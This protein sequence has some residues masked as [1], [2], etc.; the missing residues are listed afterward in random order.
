[1]LPVNGAGMAGAGRGGGSPWAGWA[2]AQVHVALPPR[3]HLCHTSPEGSEPGSAVVCRGA[4]GER[5]RTGVS[6]Q[7]KPCRWAAKRGGRAHSGV[8]SSGEAQRPGSSQPGSQGAR[9]GPVRGPTIPG[10]GVGVGTAAAVAATG[11]EQPRR[12]APVSGA[13]VGG[14]PPVQRPYSHPAAGVPQEVG[15]SLV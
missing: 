13:G 14:T 11:Q 2:V 10:R 12:Q 7:E 8:N 3:P 1:M 15:S 6:G 5:S 9:G 4:A